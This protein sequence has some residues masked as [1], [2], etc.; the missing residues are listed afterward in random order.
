MKM[1]DEGETTH[2]EIP[3]LP[4]PDKKG[5][6]G[7]KKSNAKTTLSL[8]NFM[9]LQ[10]SNNQVQ[11]NGGVSHVENNQLQRPSLEDKEAAILESCHSYIHDFLKQRGPTYAMDPNLQQ[12]I[13]NFPPEAKQVMEKVGGYRKFILLCK[14]LVVVDRIV[15]AKAHISKAQEMAFK[16]IYNNIPG[17]GPAETKPIYNPAA[18]PSSKSG[19]WASSSNLHSVG[20]SEN[21]GGSG[22]TIQYHQSGQKD[23]LSGKGVIGGGLNKNGIFNPGSVFG[24]SDQNSSGAVNEDLQNKIWTLTSHNNH[25]IKQLTEKENQVSELSKK[26]VQLNS[27]EKEY[28]AAQAQIRDQRDEIERLKTELEERR[29]GEKAEDGRS[30]QQIE[31][32]RDLIFQLQSSLEAEK[33][34]SKNLARQLE[35][36]MANLNL[37]QQNSS[38]NTNMPIGSRSSAFG[39]LGLDNPM[40]GGGG[41]MDQDTLGLIGLGGRMGGLGGMGLG[42]NIQP[43]LSSAPGQSMFGAIGSDLGQSSRGFMNKAASTSQLGLNLV[44]VGNPNTG[45]LSS[46]GHSNKLLGGYSQGLPGYSSYSAL[47]PGPFSSS[48]L[49]SNPLANPISTVPSTI[50]GHP[51]GQMGP[52]LLPPT[53]LSLS[54]SSGS[55]GGFGSAQSP[56][57]LGPNLGPIGGGGL[58]GQSVGLGGQS[59]GGGQSVGFGVGQSGLGGQSLGGQSVLGGQSLGGQNVG[60]GGQSM[61]GQNMGLGVGQSGLG[62]HSMGGPPPGL[63]S[64]G[65][66]LLGGLGQGLAGLAQTGGGSAPSTPAPAHKSNSAIRQEQLVKKVVSSIPGATDESVKHYIQVLREQHGKLSG[67]PTSR[68][69]QEITELMKQG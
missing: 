60:L 22:G 18:N 45:G 7:K 69:I 68:I 6:K 61:G 50:S 13:N 8:Q 27:L 52:S 15:A 11:E 37:H 35:S 62:G 5:K 64:Q 34:K 56:L 47:T 24:G 42:M 2:R 28:E 36:P 63:S 58:G 66:Q 55:L 51:G 48:S 40:S 67:W 32:D 16:E 10:E 43:G 12:E 41:G 53:S 23:G 4:E 30:S 46:P 31:K 38:L 44:G 49:A 25:L 19:I 54:G 1:E 57:D 59:L 3:G 17:G 14:D 26:L 33:L 20:Y 21:S 29:V 9:N 39:G 65:V